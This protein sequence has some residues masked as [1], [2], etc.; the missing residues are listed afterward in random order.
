MKVIID[1]EGIHKFQRNYDALEWAIDNAPGNYLPCLMDT[2]F[3]LKQL[4]KATKH[5][6][7]GME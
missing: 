2:L 6:Y 1:I 5:P 4:E 3:I 7:R